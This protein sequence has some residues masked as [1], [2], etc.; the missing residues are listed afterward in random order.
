LTPSGAPAHCSVH[1][2]AAAGD[3]MSHASSQDVGWIMDQLPLAAATCM[4]PVMPKKLVCTTEIEEHFP[5]FASDHAPMCAVCLSV[6]E[7]DEPCR[8]T[9]CGHEFHGDC[10]MR[11]WTQEEGKV[12][13][14][15]VCREVQRVKLV[16]GFTE[17]YDPL[18]LQQDWPGRREFVGQRP[19]R[20][21]NSS[22]FRQ[23]RRLA[24][25]GGS[26]G[27]SG[28]TPAHS[29]PEQQRQQQQQLQQQ[30]RQGQED[31]PTQAQH[32]RGR[33]TWA[34]R[35]ERALRLVPPLPR[36]VSSV[37]KALDR[38]TMPSSGPRT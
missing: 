1:C 9:K 37:L 19:L 18:K 21:R 7:A 10:I 20:A 14:C 12:L 13:C 33:S 16:G 31:R 26:R 22:E 30:V 8:R 17:P 15:P 5:V 24:R 38:S 4:R 28:R 34:W 2:V 3:A 27:P 25:R 32:R 35:R 11:W 6:V 29:V 23:Q 36:H